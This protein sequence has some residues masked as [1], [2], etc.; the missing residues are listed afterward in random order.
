V[1]E[2][3]A[4]GLD[5]V[6]ED[7]HNVAVQ[8]EFESKILKPGYHLTGSTVETRRFQGMNKLDSTLYSPTTNGVLFF[9]R[10]G[11]FGSRVLGGAIWYGRPIA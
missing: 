4:P 3:G 9:I 7:V 11:H 8:V 5:D 2:G 10:S 6:H 1:L